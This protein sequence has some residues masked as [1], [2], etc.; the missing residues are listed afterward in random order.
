MYT[1]LFYNKNHEALPELAL[2]ESVFAVLYVIEN[3]PETDPRRCLAT[4]R[5]RLRSSGRGLVDGDAA[6]PELRLWALLECNCRLHS[7]HHHAGKCQ[8]G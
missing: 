5:R 7:D 4:G 3:P 8:Q 2:L 6:D 1:L